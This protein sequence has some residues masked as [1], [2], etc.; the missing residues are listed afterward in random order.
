M[1]ALLGLP[2]KGQI[3]VTDGSIL[4]FDTIDIMAL[5]QAG[6][7]QITE[8]LGDKMKMKITQEGF[9]AVKN[10]FTNERR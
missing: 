7:L 10:D 8:D 9:D 5:V 3:Q 2:Q 4:E 1:N 6:Y